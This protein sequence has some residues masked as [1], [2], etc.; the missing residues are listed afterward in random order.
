MTLIAGIIIGVAAMWLR[1]WVLAKP[2]S[3]L[4]KLPASELRALLEQA[5]ASLGPLHAKSLEE[6]SWRPDYE[7][8]LRDVAELRDALRIV[9]AREHHALVERGPYR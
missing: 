9:E 3:P 2:E 6:S 8:R 4:L 5:T 7:R 1:D